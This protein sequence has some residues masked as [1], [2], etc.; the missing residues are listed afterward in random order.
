MPLIGKGP[1]GRREHIPGVDP[2][3]EFTTT[4]HHHHTGDGDPVTDREAGEVLEVGGGLRH[5]EQLDASSGVLERTEGQLALI[6][7][8]HESPGDRHDN[9]R[10]GAGLEGA[11]VLDDLG[12]GVGDV[13]AIREVGHQLF[14][15]C[16]IRRPWRVRKGSTCSIVSDT[17]AIRWA[18]PPVATTLISPRASP[19]RRTMP[20]I[21]A[22]KP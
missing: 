14:R 1:L 17:G 6:A 22:A 5:G 11:M 12:G 8:E 2:D 13:V 21:I 7:A 10:L 15:S 9:L 16:T 19:K 4:G 18:S 20:S 3:A